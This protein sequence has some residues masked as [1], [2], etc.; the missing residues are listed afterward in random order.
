M[1]I[2]LSGRLKAFNYAYN[3]FLIWNI[4]AMSLILM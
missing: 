2:F 1:D 4:D 3:K